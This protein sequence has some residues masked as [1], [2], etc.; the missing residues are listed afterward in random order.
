MDVRIP[1]SAQL[2]GQQMEIKSSPAQP[3]E[4]SEGGLEARTLK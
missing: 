3:R 2:S 1:G 4:E